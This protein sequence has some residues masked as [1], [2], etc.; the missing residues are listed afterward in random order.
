MT[1]YVPTDHDKEAKL[2]QKAFA[3]AQIDAE[4][5]ERNFETRMK[6]LGKKKNRAGM[7]EGLDNYRVSVWLAN[8]KAA[9]AINLMTLEKMAVIAEC[10]VQD[11]LD[12]K[13]EN[14]TKTKEEKENVRKINC[15][16]LKS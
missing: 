10:D 8:L 16:K 4:I 1:S 15:N 5:I 7:A 11:L 2:K 6:F 13:G 9:S 14:L 12:P 3:K